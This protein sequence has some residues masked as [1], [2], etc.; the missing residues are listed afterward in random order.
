MLELK[1]ASLSIGFQVEAGECSFAKLNGHVA[2]Q[3]QYAVIHSS[4]GH[5]AA[6]VAAP[7]ELTVQIADPALGV[8]NLSETE[9]REGIGWDGAVLFLKDTEAVGG[10]QP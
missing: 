7:T 3:G 1:R 6:V 9:L 2:R 5:F 8:Q 4:K 10:S